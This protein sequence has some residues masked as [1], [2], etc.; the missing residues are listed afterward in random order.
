MILND[1]GGVDG[2]SSDLSW[3]LG[4]GLE[5][6]ELQDTFEALNGTGN[7]AGNSIQGN[8]QVNVLRGQGGNDFLYGTGANDQLYGG[9]GVDQLQG[10]DGNDVLRGDAG[11]DSIYGSEFSDGNDRISVGASTAA[12][13]LDRIYSFD[14]TTDGD[15]DPGVDKID[16]RALFDALGFGYTTL[17]QATAAGA[18]MLNTAFVDGGSEMDT[19]ILVDS[20]PGGDFEGVEFLRIVDVTGL[21]NVNFMLQ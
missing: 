18:L 7:G 15:S 13:G 12:N 21:L 6:L 8:S 9:A 17:Q 11:N 20:V 4:A 19:Q 14:V 1:T 3:T 16:L 5:N 2:V 10:G